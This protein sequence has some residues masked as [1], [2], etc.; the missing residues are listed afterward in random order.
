VGGGAFNCGSIVGLTPSGVLK[1]NYSFSCKAGG[2][3]PDGGVI[4][5]SDGNLYGTTSE[6]G[7]HKKGTIFKFDTTSKTVSFIYNFGSVADDGSIPESPLV[8]GTDG[9]LYGTT[10][11]GGVHQSGTLFQFTLAGDYK[12]LYSFKEQFLGGV[13]SGLMQH[14]NG[15]FYGT[16]QGGGGF[17]SGTIYT[18]DM[19]LGPFITFVNSSGKIG[20]K[21]QILGQGLTGTTSVTFNGIGAKTF[22]VVTDTYMTAVVP[23]GATT[24][25]VTVATPG[26]SLTSNRNFTVLK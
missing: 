9:N 14:T 12:Q 22:T 21:V 10:G 20:A 3:Y 26:G 4:V 17:N 6:G 5:A 2:S 23:D 25:S 1:A 8:Q 11:F 15:L 24:G 13:T 7:T 16:T 19:G 18:L